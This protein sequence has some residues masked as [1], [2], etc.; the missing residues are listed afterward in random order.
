MP[1]TLHK[2]CV[3]RLR[4]VL[5]NALA[6][7]KVDHRQYLDYRTAYRFEGVDK[8]LPT[9]G[10]AKQELDTIFGDDERL[11]EFS[12]DWISR[13]LKESQSYEPDFKGELLSSLAGFGDLGEVAQRIAADFGALPYRYVV[14]LPLPD[15]LAKPL[16]PFAGS[17]TDDEAPSPRLCRI[18]EHFKAKYNSGTD[19]GEGPFSSGLLGLLAVGNPLMPESG[20]CL[21]IDA[22]G[23]SINT[24]RPSLR[25]TLWNRRALS[26]VS[27]WRPSFSTSDVQKCFLDL[28]QYAGTSTFIVSMAKS[29]VRI[30]SSKQT[31][32]SQLSSVD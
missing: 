6:P 29:L 12:T 21:Q 15:S 1:I 17:A 11:P 13:R 23:L 19:K 2:D 3:A 4:A 18:D 14:S 31:Q 9:S 5:A 24:A 30:L 32:T 28:V 20:F 7:I 16:E 10:S 22:E 26:L 25:R 8:V 27:A